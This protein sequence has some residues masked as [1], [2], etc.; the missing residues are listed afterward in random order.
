MRASMANFELYPWEE[1]QLSDNQPA[2]A[3]AVV[4]PEQPR[5]RLV[6]SQQLP[7]L[8]AQEQFFQSDDLEES[9]HFCAEHFTYTH[10][11]ISVAQI[12]MD[13]EFVLSVN[14]QQYHMTE[15]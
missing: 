15:K 3:L 6:P 14:E 5:V 8:F 7:D 10:S 13:E 11:E 1:N 9:I 12:S 4:H 2:A